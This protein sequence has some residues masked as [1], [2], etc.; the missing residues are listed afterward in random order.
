MYSPIV[1]VSG[2]L[3]TGMAEFSSSYA[4]PELV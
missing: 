2:A 3:R 4:L 1:I